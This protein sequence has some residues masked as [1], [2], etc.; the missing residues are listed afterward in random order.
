[1]SAEPRVLSGIYTDT[2]ARLY[3]QQGFFDHALAI[4]QHLAQAQPRNRQWRER[5]AA[6]EQQRALAACTAADE[7]GKAPGELALPPLAP[8]QTPERRVLAYLED[9]LRILRQQRPT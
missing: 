2:L 8:V 5:I 9:W 1:M 6:L 3:L 4:Y 7:G